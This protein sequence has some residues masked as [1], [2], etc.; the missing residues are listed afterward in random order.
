MT[1]REV[2]LGL[3]AEIISA[4]VSNNAVQTDQLPKLIQQVFNKFI[5]HR[6][7]ICC[8]V[9]TRAS[10]PDQEV[11]PTRSHHLSRLRETVLDAQ[12]TSEG[13]TIN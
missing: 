9:A 6:A 5:S 10:S 3:A 8:N 13:Q 7:K 12:A 1:E 11:C 4:H 2:V